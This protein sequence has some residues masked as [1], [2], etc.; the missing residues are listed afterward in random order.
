MLTLSGAPGFATAA[1][2]AKAGQTWLASAT[3]PVEIDA[4]AVTHS[5]SATVTILLEWLRAAPNKTCTIS[6]IAL[7]DVMQ[8]LVALSRLERVLP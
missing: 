6:H 3:G 1:A 2:L 7:P 5:S 8:E 4:R